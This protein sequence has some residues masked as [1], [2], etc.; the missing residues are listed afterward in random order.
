MYQ[1]SVNKGEAKYIDENYLF[2]NTNTN[3]KQN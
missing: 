1:H 2:I 3:T